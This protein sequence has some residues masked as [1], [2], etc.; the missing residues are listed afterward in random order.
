MIKLKTSH[1]IKFCDSLGDSYKQMFLWGNVWYSCKAQFQWVILALGIYLIIL[2][3]ELESGFIFLDL[4]LDW[5]LGRPLAV[6]FSFP[7]KPNSIFF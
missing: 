4:L 7:S 1:F 2:V 6:Y 5:F 3:C